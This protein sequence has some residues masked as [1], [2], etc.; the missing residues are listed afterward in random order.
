MRRCA[1]DT[2]L[3]S[4]WRSARGRSPRD[5]KAK[6]ICEWFDLQAGERASELAQKVWG[7]S[8][9]TGMRLSELET[10]AKHSQQL[11]A[12]Q[13]G[14]EALGLFSIRMAES[15]GLSLSGRDLPERVKERMKSAGLSEGGWR[16]LGK[17]DSG[18]DSATAQ[19]MGWAKEITPEQSFYQEALLLIMDRDQ[20]ARRIPK[21]V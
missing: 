15:L 7:G 6:R 8:V 21:S 16:L 5:D 4:I 10:L 13:E 3:S 11:W 17:L 1:S 20:G 2:P 14:Q 9:P 19:W 12:A 18:P